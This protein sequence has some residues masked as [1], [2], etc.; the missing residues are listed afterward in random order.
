MQ[1]QTEW[2][3]TEKTS[4]AL[5]CML[6]LAAGSILGWIIFGRI[7]DKCSIKIT[8]LI[9]MLVTTTAYAFLLLYGAIYEFSYFKAIAMTFT[10][11][12]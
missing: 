3:S 2:K 4:R 8:V 10:W 1:E 7:T 9:N 6:G 5:L 12:L 11:G